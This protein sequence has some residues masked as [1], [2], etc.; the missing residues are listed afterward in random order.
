MGQSTG[1]TILHQLVLM[2]VLE[3]SDS[4]RPLLRLMKGEVLNPIDYRACRQITYSTH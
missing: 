3:E 2:L 4:G 1:S